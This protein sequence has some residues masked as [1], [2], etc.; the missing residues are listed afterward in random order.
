MKS[1]V[2]KVKKLKEKLVVKKITMNNN[3]TKWHAQMIQMTLRFLLKSNTISE[4][5]R[6]GKKYKLTKKIK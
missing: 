3:L 6:L 2:V 5:G 4:Q 1:K